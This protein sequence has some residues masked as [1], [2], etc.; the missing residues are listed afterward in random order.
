MAPQLGLQTYRLP[1][2]VVQLQNITVHTLVL[3][4]INHLKPIGKY[5]YH[6]I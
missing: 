2:V 1:G 5:I 6:L 4:T 3:F